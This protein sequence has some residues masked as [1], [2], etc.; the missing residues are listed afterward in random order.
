MIPSYYGKIIK[1]VVRCTDVEALPYVTMYGSTKIFYLRRIVCCRAS[2]TVQLALRVQLYTCTGRATKI[3]D[4]FRMNEDILALHTLLQ[5]VYCT[6]T[7]NVT[8]N[9][10]VATRAATSM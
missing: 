10:Y 1:E 7:I 4:F 6:C 3:F 5:Y 2:P 8:M 9:T